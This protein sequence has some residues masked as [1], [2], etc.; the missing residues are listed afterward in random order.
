MIYDALIIGGGPAGLTAALY[1]LRAGKTAL[2][3][4]KESIGGQISKSPRLENYPSIASISGMEFSNNLYEQVEKLG[5]DFEFDE[6]LSIIK[7]EDGFKI[8]CQYGDF[9]GKTVILATGCHHKTLGL[10]REE[11]LVGHGISY[12]ATCDAD[13]FA[14]EDVIVIGDA[15]TALQYAIQ[16]T[17]KSTKVI[18][19]TLFDKFFADKILVDRIQE[20]PKIEVFMEYSAQEYIGKDELEGVRF[21]STKTG[22]EKYFPCKGCFIAIGQ[23][24]CNEPFAD[25]V[26]LENGFVLTNEFMETKTPGIYAVGDC[27]KK[28]MRQVV[29]ATSDAAIAAMRIVNALNTK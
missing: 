8:H 23:I 6:V 10:P 26:D 11:E 15:N 14:G 29:T 2:V 1:L 9:E 19:V 25:F 27:R 17:A 3:L 21:V 22:E 18:I 4:E 7:L 12:C 16:L 28:G 13:F 20:N 24:P 5:A